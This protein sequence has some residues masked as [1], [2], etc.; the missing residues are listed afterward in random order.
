M[1][2]WYN[3][4]I[5]QDSADSFVIH[6][7]DKSYSYYLANNGYDVV[8]FLFDFSGLLIQEETYIHANTRS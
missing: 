3:N 2:S 1:D 4:Y 7:E 6:H 5:N 8:W